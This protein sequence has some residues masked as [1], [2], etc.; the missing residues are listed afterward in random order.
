V[1][2]AG[3]A[4]LIACAPSSD[5][6][7]S[8]Q[9][10]T[11]VLNDTTITP[12][13]SAVSTTT[14]APG[15]TTETTFML[16]PGISWDE[17]EARSPA[18]SE[19]AQSDQ[20]DGDTRPT[21]LLATPPMDPGLTG[22]LLIPGEDGITV[23]PFYGESR[24]ISGPASLAVIFALPDERGGIVFQTFGG[25]RSVPDSIQHL[26]TGANRPAVL[27]E[28]QPGEFLVPIS[29]A[30]GRLYYLV[31][32]AH[33]LLPWGVPQPTVPR[34]E[35]W[36]MSIDEGTETLEEVLADVIGI[37][38]PISTNGDLLVVRLKRKNQYLWPPCNWF[39][40]ITLNGNLAAD[41]PYPG[42]LDDCLGRYRPYL[43]RA[44][45][46]DQ[47]VYWVQQQN[48]NDVFLEAM[49]I[50]TGTRKS[51]LVGSRSEGVYAGNIDPYLAAAPDGTFALW[52][53]PA[54][55]SVVLAGRLGSDGIELFSTREMPELY[56]CRCSQSHL[57]ATVYTT[58][59]DLSELATLES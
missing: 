22:G 49:D 4:L 58:P 11:V 3:L 10:T 41:N 50:A 44:Q 25:S 42:K 2:A 32:R 15:P 12:P 55:R 51:V 17:I 46:T 21:T 39:E 47:A 16:P 6:D 26:A 59:I 37:N 43:G 5:A 19:T 36:S 48:S 7:P 27:V 20:A 9:A 1:L 33:R 28:A 29:V 14:Q 13:T 52:E 34:L 30:N 8:V 54:E 56:E 45:V 24:L 35:V 18:F 53:T 23:S 31:K 38:D 40:F 57:R